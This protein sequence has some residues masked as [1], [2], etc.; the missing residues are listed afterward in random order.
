M[1]SN[2]DNELD[3]ITATFIVTKTMN[4][5]QMQHALSSAATQQDALVFAV[6]EDAILQTHAHLPAI[7]FFAM[8]SSHSYLP[9]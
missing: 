4:S 1:F 9:Y 3:R 2:R 8:F 5:I 7:P 6:K